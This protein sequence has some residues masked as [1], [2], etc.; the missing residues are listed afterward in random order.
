[1][2]RLKLEDQD[3]AFAMVTTLHLMPWIENCLNG[4][5]VGKKVVMPWYAQGCS[6][7]ISIEPK[8]FSESVAKKYAPKKD[9]K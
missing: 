8:R 7:E 4:K 6:F 5:M 9:K 3:K 2:K 1:M